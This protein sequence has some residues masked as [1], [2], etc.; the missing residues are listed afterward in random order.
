[1]DPLSRGANRSAVAAR[2][3]QPATRIRCVAATD[4]DGVELTQGYST[5]AQADGSWV[6]QFA[7]TTLQG[8]AVQLE[9]RSG[10]LA[11][12]LGSNDQ[13][14]VSRFQQMALGRQEDLEKE[15]RHE[16]AP[17]D[18]AELRGVVEELFA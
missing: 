12:S 17:R 6:L 11:E 7:P 5:R 15:L 4:V 2:R 14:A 1:M 8:R 18:V 16:G 3:S 9:T 13:G 10:N